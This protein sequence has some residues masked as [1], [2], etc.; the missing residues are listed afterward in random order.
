GVFGPGLEQSLS[1]HAPRE[2]FK[3]FAPMIAQVVGK[4]RGVVPDWIVTTRGPGS[5]TGVRLSVGTARNLSQLWNIP[6][7]G[8]DSLTLYAYEAA[9]L[10]TMSHP[11]VV[12]IDGKQNRVYAKVVLPG[13]TLLETASS[14]CRDIA[15]GDLLKNA[16]GG[17]RFFADDPDAV[18]A[19]MTRA[20]MESTHTTIEPLPV[21]RAQSLLDI[22]LQLQDQIELV[23][24]REFTPTYLRDDP[25]HAKFPQGFNNLK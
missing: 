23:T 17:A 16:P 7:L 13:E 12:M 25:A 10:R 9:D 2:S 24:W 14:P 22:G 21:P 15:P 19:Y 8:I 4:E 18:R 1:D 20:G 3:H 6:I 5:F 11:L